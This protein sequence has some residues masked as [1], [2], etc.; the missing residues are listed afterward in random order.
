MPSPKSSRKN[1]R[2]ANG[3]NFGNPPSEKKWK[4]MAHV[5]KWNMF[6]RKF[7]V[8]VDGIRF[9]HDSITNGVQ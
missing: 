8:N 9:V 3:R 2:K 7:D 5:P 4:K 1:K 6:N